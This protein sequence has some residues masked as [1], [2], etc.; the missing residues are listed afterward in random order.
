MP[1]T[2]RDFVTTVEKR[3]L[4][5]KAKKLPDGTIDVQ[6]EDLGWF[7]GLKRTGIAVCFGFEEPELKAGDW[8]TITIAREG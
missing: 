1:R 7:V 8:V 2:F 6:R 4:A 3:S 5:K